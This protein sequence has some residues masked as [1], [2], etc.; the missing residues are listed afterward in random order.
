MAV[1]ITVDQSGSARA[2]SA[3][4]RLYRRRSGRGWEQ[5]LLRRG[6]RRRRS[7]AARSLRRSGTLLRLSIGREATR[8][9]PQPNRHEAPTFS[10]RCLPTRRLR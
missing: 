4:S 5:S 7:Q 10:W 6:H 2:S 3:T 9:R 8:G 1:L